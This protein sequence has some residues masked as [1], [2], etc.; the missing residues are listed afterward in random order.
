MDTIEYVN[1]QNTGLIKER[2]KLRARVIELEEL[3]KFAHRE[4]QRS[5]GSKSSSDFRWQVSQSL[6]RLNRPAPSASLEAHDREV[7]AKALE[8]FANTIGSYPMPSGSYSNSVK[9]TLV[10]AREQAVRIRE[11]D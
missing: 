11:G 5:A 9:W 2:N 4:G 7:A 10:Q 6:K 3:V 8:D 1:A